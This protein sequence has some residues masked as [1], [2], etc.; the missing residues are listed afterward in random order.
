[1]GPLVL[2]AIL[3]G[4][5]RVEGARERGGRLL[6]AAPL[7]PPLAVGMRVAICAVVVMWKPMTCQAP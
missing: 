5:T 6:R 4:N 1:M 2:G 3:P 7:W